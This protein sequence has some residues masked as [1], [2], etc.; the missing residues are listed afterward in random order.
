LA[1]TRVH[2]TITIDQKDQMLRAGKFLWLKKAQASIITRHNDTSISASHEGYKSLGIIHSRFIHQPETYELIVKDSISFSKNNQDHLVSIHWLLPDWQW[3][4]KDDLLTLGLDDRR[5]D[6]R[7][8]CKTTENTPIPVSNI[9]LVRAGIALLGNHQ[10]EIL[11]WISPTYNVKLPALSL[12]LS[13]KV[14][15]T[16]EIT[17]SWQF[18]KEK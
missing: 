8:F 6:L 2:N 16:V 7:I 1:T 14:N 17:S 10:E 11:G 18:R 15:R 5:I 13:W 4:W 3:K 9:S 12:T